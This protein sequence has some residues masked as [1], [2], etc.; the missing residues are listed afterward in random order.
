MGDSGRPTG[1]VTGTEQ[2]NS[3]KQRHGCKVVIIIVVV[4]S[5]KKKKGGGA[6]EMAQWLEH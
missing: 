4:K 1:R 2:N 6:G 5:L 3:L